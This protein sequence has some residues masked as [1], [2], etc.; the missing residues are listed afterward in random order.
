MYPAELTLEKA[1]EL[2]DNA[3][4]ERG[5]DHVYVPDV[6]GSSCFYVHGDKPGCIIGHVLHQFGIPLSELKKVEGKRAALAVDELD[7]RTEKYLVSQFLDH[8][9]RAQDNGS[10]WGD[11]VRYARQSLRV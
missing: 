9:Q 5:A 8:V 7:I 4:A 11:A 1:I 2:L 10:P 3:I 6:A